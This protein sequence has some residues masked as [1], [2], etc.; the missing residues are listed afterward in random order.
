MNWLKKLFGGVTPAP[1]PV[2]QRAPARVLSIPE[3]RAQLGHLGCPAVHLRPVSHSRFC[4]LGGLPLLPPDAPWPQWN[5]RPQ[6][7]LAQI[8]LA[9]IH[10]ALPSF[11]PSTGYLYFFYDQDQGTSSCEMNEQHSWRVLYAAGDCSAFEQR[12]APPGLDSEHIYKEKPVAAQRIDVLPHKPGID[13]NADESADNYVELRA[14]AFDGMPA[15]QMLG[16][17]SP[18]QNDDMELECQLESNRIFG[19]AQRSAAP[20]VA[21]LKKGASDW[22][23]LLQLETDDDTGWMW[24]DAGTLYFWVRE[25]DASQGDFSKAWMIFECC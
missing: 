23:L 13:L 25:Q 11:L 8:D 19:E 12:A 1:T 10:V 22:K 14:S 15:H 7:F 6:S 16:Y 5:D 21:D 24:G 20:R 17:P 2:Q 18:I 4:K 9:E 3:L